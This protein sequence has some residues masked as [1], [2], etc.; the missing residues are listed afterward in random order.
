PQVAHFDAEALEDV[1]LVRAQPAQVEAPRLPRHRLRDDGDG[2]VLELV[3]VAE[4]QGDSG[5][6][7]GKEPAGEVP[8]GGALE[9]AGS[10]GGGA[11]A[12]RFTD[13]AASRH[14]RHSSVD[15]R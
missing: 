1:L 10:D 14:R 13:H 2:V 7:L 4:I 12:T 3:A 5:Q 9:P 8:G 15:L 11:V 6:M